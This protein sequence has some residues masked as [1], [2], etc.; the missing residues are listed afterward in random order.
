[1]GAAGVPIV[2]TG[3][4][5]ISILSADAGHS[6]RAPSMKTPPPPYRLPMFGWDNASL[7]FSLSPPLFSLPVYARLAVDPTDCC[8]PV[9]AWRMKRRLGEAVQVGVRRDAAGAR[10]GGISRHQ[11]VRQHFL[12]ELQPMF[13]RERKRSPTPLRAHLSRRNVAQHSRRNIEHFSRRNI[14]AACCRIVNVRV[15]AHRG[16]A[17][18]S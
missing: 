15:I 5:R 14:A 17:A 6:I 2:E 1:M 13:M 4:Q 11:H 10:E 18:F 3:K 12:S 9:G 16:A 8:L 7:L